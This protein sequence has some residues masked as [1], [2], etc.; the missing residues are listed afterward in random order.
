MLANKA[1]GDRPFHEISLIAESEGLFNHA[2]ALYD[3]LTLKQWRR[4]RDV[5]LP[6]TTLQLE[7]QAIQYLTGE[8]WIP[9]QPYGYPA[10]LQAM[11]LNVS[12]SAASA[13]NPDRRSECLDVL[14]F[15]FLSME[16]ASSQNKHAAMSG[17][18]AF[19]W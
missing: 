18:W 11:L 19:T 4:L 10:I 12:L 6:A 2:D 17:R 8:T 5:I 1:K 16:N 9:G 7:Q 3:G 13:D 15:L 14:S